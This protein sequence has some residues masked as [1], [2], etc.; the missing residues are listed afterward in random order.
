MRRLLIM[1]KLRFGYESPQN[2]RLQTPDSCILDFNL[3]NTAPYDQF[4]DNKECE[5]A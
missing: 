1:V 2:I 4:N 3:D 5:S